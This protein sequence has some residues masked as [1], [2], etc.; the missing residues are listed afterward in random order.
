MMADIRRGYQMVLFCVEN[1]GRSAI[2]RDVEDLPEDVDAA[3]VLVG[4]AH[5][6]PDHAAARVVHRQRADEDAAVQ[7]LAENGVGRDA[8]AHDI[9]K[10]E[11]G[12]ARDRADA[13]DR[14]EIAD[15]IGAALAQSDEAL[16]LQV[17]GYP[18]R[19]SLR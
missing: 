2:G 13:G 19:G 4:R 3:P 8:R 16:F 17:D 18:P 15:Q 7:H 9:D 14:V 12:L 11:I 10:D 1:G 6:D 5:R